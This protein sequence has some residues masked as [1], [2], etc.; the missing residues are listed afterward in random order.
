M[1]GSP[2]ARFT[3]H[4][5]RPRHFQKL[6]LPLLG[7]AF[8]MAPMNT[9]AATINLTLSP[10][11]GLATASFVAR[12]AVS[13][14]CGQLPPGSTATFVFYWDVFVASNQFAS[15]TSQ[16]CDPRLNRFSANAPAYTPKPPGNRVGVHTVL[17]SA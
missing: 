2:R 11:Q 13:Y 14:P 12:A 5:M 7:A 17:V 10:S 16:P 9:L 6:V 3:I 4:R 8:A 1:G 15:V